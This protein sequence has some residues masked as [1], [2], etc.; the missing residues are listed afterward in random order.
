MI[1]A[2]SLIIILIITI[3]VSLLFVILDYKFD[4]KIKYFS[5][6]AK[7]KILYYLILFIW[8]AILFLLLI[9]NY[10]ID[11]YY[12]FIILIIC[13]ALFINLYSHTNT[14]NK[15]Y[16]I[17]IKNVDLLIETKNKTKKLNLKHK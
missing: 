5:L 1:Y 8:T 3:I 11:N 2:F 9:M 15:A 6:I 7:N 4:I 17:Y 14:W 12:N 10:P 16:N 13:F